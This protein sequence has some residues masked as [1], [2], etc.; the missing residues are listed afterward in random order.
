MRD[1]C[2][3]GISESIAVFGHTLFRVNSSR[4]WHTKEAMDIT[5]LILLILFPIFIIIIGWRLIA[6]Y[7]SDDFSKGYYMGKIAFVAFSY[8]WIDRIDGLHHSGDYCDLFLPAGCC[9]RRRVCQ[10]WRWCGVLQQNSLHDDLVHDLRSD[11]R[12]AL[13]RA[14][15]HRVLLRDGGY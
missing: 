15:L 8:Y 1:Q 10:L 4:S 11:C 9:E 14:A 13:H 3:K 5:L 6:Y 7:L 2:E 12:A